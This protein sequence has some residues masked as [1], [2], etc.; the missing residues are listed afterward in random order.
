MKVSIITATFNSDKTL[1]DTIQCV[2]GQDYPDIEHLIVDGGSKD[3]TIDIIKSMENHIHKWISEP[4][5]G[6]YDAMNKGLKMA[7]GDIVAILNSDDFYPNNQVISKVVS[8]LKENGADTAYGDLQ[9]VDPKETSRIVRNWKAGDFSSNKFYVGW[10][11]PH[12][13]FFVKREVYE[14]YGN[15]DTSFWTSADYE[16][17]LRFLFK[18]A[19]STVYIPE[20][21]VK[22]RTGGQSNINL[23][24][25]LKANKE[26]RR[27]WK[28]NGLKPR[29]YTTWLKPLRKV[30]QFKRKWLR[31]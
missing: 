23:A 7:T 20:V 14:K 15:F 21:L 31:F 3:G 27:A 18:H 17:M 28:I 24:N 8:A 1:A 12:P 29:F 26:D 25:R 22:M 16:L 9:Y 30:S 13:T 4:D 5:K 19:V 2:Q 11:P 6:I 10:M